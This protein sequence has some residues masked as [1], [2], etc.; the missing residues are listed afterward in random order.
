MITVQNNTCAITCQENGAGLVLLD[1]KRGT[2]WALDEKSLVYGNDVQGIRT[3]LIPCQAQT[4]GYDSLLVSYQ[5]GEAPLDIR[6][7]LRDEFIEVRLPAPTRA[8]IGYISL[9]G[10]FMPVGEKLKLVLPIMQG[11]LWD[12]R[13]PAVDLIRGEGSHERRNPITSGDNPQ[14]TSNQR[15]VAS[16]LNTT[17]R[18]NIFIITRFAS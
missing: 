11:M 12:G 14:L 3:P 13:G 7:I 16:S 2:R 9:P 1:I 5:A 15:P 18:A 17:S 4:D 8:D 10:S 6:Y